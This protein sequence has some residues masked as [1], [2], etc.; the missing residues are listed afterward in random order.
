MAAF[1]SFLDICE[2]SQPLPKLFS[3]PSCAIKLVRT[4]FPYEVADASASISGGKSK[5]KKGVAES[6]RAS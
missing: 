6:H 2:S 1:P 5:L 3:L 4:G